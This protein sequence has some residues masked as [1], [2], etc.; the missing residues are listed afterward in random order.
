MTANPRVSIVLPVWNGARFLEDT[1]SSL[2]IQSSGDYELI[3]I[4]DGSDDA[5]PQILRRAAQADRRVNL[6][7]NSRRSGMGYVFNQGIGAATGEYIAR[8][9]ADDIAHPERL[10]RQ[11]DFLDTNRDVVV[12]GSQ[13]QLIDVRGE[14]LGI[15][16]YPLGNDAL[17]RAM[18]RY[19]PFAHPATMYRRR[20][21]ADLGGYEP[22]W[23]PAEDLDLWIRLARRGDLANHPDALLSYRVHGDSVSS[24]QGLRMQI[25]STRVRIN[26]VKYHGFF[27]NYLDMFLSVAQLCA[28]PLPYAY[29][30]RLFAFYRR[31]LG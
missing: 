3:I 23:A 14:P 28:V 6:I 4:D 18:A 13:V 1:L 27:M 25:Q 12:V 26:G 9:D 16:R 8:M 2:R 15:R 21:V 10:A 11:V 24:R 31:I 30:M 7:T 29:R 17:R 20:I 19:S 5:T 22:R